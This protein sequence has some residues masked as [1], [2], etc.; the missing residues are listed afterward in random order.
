[1]QPKNLSYFMLLGTL[2]FFAA[3]GD[4]PDNRLVDIGS[5]ESAAQETRQRSVEPESTTPAEESE[6]VTHLSFWSED[7]TQMSPHIPAPNAAEQ[8]TTSFCGNGIMEGSEQCDDGAPNGDDGCVSCSLTTAH[9]VFLKISSIPDRAERLF[10]AVDGGELATPLV[11]VAPV[12]PYLER[13]YVHVPTGTGG[14]FRARVI[15]VVG[16]GLPVAIAGGAVREIEIGFGESAGFQ[17]ELQEFGAEV[18]SDT[19]VAIQV[20][21]RLHLKMTIIDPAD[22]LSG[23]RWGRIW[24][25]QEPFE[26]LSARRTSGFLEQMAPGSV[27]L[28]AELADWGPNQERVLYFQVGQPIEHFR[29]K[30]EIPYIVSPSTE[31]GESLYSVFVDPLP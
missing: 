19:P 13:Q 14:P 20:G 8:D 30:G 21:D 17:V 28:T 23:Q 9:S 24:Y 6:I 27:D 15:S 18:A 7:P 26:D 2:C 22:A 29:S 31:A 25:A 5:V 10:V 12:R 4:L 16:T 11:H 1:M 3:C